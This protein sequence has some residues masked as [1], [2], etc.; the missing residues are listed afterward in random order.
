MGC[1]I[2]SYTKRPVQLL[3]LLQPVRAASL[4][5]SRHLNEILF[6]SENHIYISSILLDILNLRKAYYSILI[7]F[8]MQK[9][10]PCITSGRHVPE[11]WCWCAYYNFYR[12]AATNTKSIS[13]WHCKKKEEIG[14]CGENSHSPYK[15]WLHRNSLALKTTA[16]CTNPCKL[17]GKQV[18]QFFSGFS[19]SN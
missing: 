9:T 16:M 6:Y 19:C 18:P 10:Y 7:Q 4:S 13:I 12:Q 14:W 8:V 15:E 1:A 3:V 11:A 17:R 5:H 2:E